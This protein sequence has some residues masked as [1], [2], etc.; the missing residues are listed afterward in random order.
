MENYYTNADQMFFYFL[1]AKEVFSVAVPAKN[2]V[3]LG[4]K[5][6]VTPSKMMWCYVDL[7]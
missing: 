6:A 5:I 7:L 1:T 2:Y 4:L 3:M